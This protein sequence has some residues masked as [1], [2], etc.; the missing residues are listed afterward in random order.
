M[1]T[2]Q[3][4]GIYLNGTD[5]TDTPL[6]FGTESQSVRDLEVVLTTRGTELSGSVTDDRGVRLT[7]YTAIVFAMD[8][9]LWYADSRFLT[10]T[11][12]ET[13]GT[14]VLRGVPPG[15]YFVATVDRIPGT[16]WQDPAFLDSLAPFASRV[17]LAE[18][19]QISVVPRLLVR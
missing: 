11:T 19:Q 10:R 15:Q 16:R 8:R 5:V 1:R 13:D 12:P 9:A 2:P 3:R 7:D 4:R 6:P 17:T 14:F 18:G